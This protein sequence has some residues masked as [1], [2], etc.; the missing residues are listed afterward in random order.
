MQAKCIRVRGRHGASS[1]RLS[2]FVACLNPSHSLYSL[3]YSSLRTLACL[4]APTRPPAGLPP[5]PAR[6]GCLLYQD[7]TFAMALHRIPMLTNVHGRVHQHTSSR[8]PRACGGV[9]AASVALP[10][11]RA[12]SWTRSRWCG[13]RRGPPACSATQTVEGSEARVVQGVG[14]RVQVG[15][16]LGF[17]SPSGWGSPLE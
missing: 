7:G 9:R 14:F 1:T 13:A 8:C 16:R 5:R 15:L 17:E 11:R 2:P 3:L 6:L 4:L 12:Q 10:E